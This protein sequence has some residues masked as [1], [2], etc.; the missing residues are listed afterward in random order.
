MYCRNPDEE[1]RR[2][3]R[4]AA[5][6]DPLAA[7]RLQLL[8][9]RAGDPEAIITV[10]LRNLIEKLNAWASRDGRS[11]LRGDYSFTWPGEHPFEKLCWGTSLI[12]WT[13]E[14]AC[15]L[16]WQQEIAIDDEYYDDL[17]DQ[18][19]D[20]RLLRPVNEVEVNI[21]IAP[22]LVGTHHG[23]CSRCGRGTDRVNE[24]AARG[25]CYD[26]QY[27]PRLVTTPNASINY[28]RCEWRPEL[29]RAGSSWHSGWLE[30]HRVVD[31]V[32]PLFELV[33]L[34]SQHLGIMGIEG[35]GTTR[36]IHFMRQE[37]P[38]DRP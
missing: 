18:I 1:L 2:V 19:Q 3:E 23:K 11:I 27:G 22:P 4:E 10:M 9:A 17:Q 12:G 25:L 20:I 6:G 21:E 15:Q 33:N 24:P 32:H 36:A 16:R 34:I 28:I 30:Y 5:S 7:E 37:G 31:E 35:I 8:R 14:G 26:C 38:T 29:I 13:E